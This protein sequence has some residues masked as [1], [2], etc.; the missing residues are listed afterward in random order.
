[1]RPTAAIVF[2]TLTVVT[3]AEAGEPRRH[4]GGFFLRLAPGGGFASSKITETGDELEFRGVSGN[5]DIA[6][7]A[8]I[9]ENLAI[10]ANVGGWS[11]V[12]PTVRFNGREEQVQDLGFTLISYGAGFT[13]YVGPS[14]VYLTAWGGAAELELDFEGD[15]D[16]SDPGFAFEVGVGKE[17]WVGDRWGVGVSASGGYHSIPPGDASGHFKGPS[18]AVRFS[19]TR[20]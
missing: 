3:G 19:A 18:F 14:N 10:H 1:M 5:V 20:N 7:G 16:T 15:T 4:D 17:W 13:W 9:H 2:L 6:I 11:L 12:D 8:V